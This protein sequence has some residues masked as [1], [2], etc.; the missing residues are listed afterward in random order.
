M[1]KQRVLK[2]F[3]ANLLRS[4]LVLSKKCCYEHIYFSLMI[5]ASAPL[6]NRMM[7]P[8][9]GSFTITLIICRSEENS[10]L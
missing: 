8:E 2:P 1:P 3:L 9:V 7:Q 6:A 5:F 10:I 4:C